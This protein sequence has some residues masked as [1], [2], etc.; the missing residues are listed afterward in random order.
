[1]RNV[2]EIMRLRFG[3]GRSQDA[4]AVACR[5]GKTTVHDCLKR[6]EKAGISWPLPDELDDLALEARL[7]PRLAVRVST[8]PTPDWSFVHA[9]LRRP[10]VT[11]QLL[12]QEYIERDPGGLSYSRYCEL[13]SDWL[14]AS[15]ISMRQIHRAGEKLFIDFAGTTVPVYDPSTGARR[16]AQI[17]VA[18][19][20]ASNYTYAEAVWSQDLPTW[21]GCHVRA[22]NFFECVPHIGVPDNLKAGVDKACRY[23]PDINETYAEL[24]RH[25]SFAVIPTRARAPKD[26]A[27]VEAGVLLVTRWI[28]AALR[29][30][31]FFSL[32]ELNEAIADLLERLNAKPFQKMPG[33]RRS[34]FLSLDKPN[35]Q[36]LPATPYVYADVVKAKVNIDYHAAIFDHFYSAPYQL[37]GERVTARVTSTT[38]EILHNNRRVCTHRR[39]YEAWKHTTLPEHLPKAHRAHAEWT[40]SRIIDWAAKTGEST[41]KLV[42]EIIKSRAHP[43]Q[44][45][46]AALGVI[47]LTDRYGKERVEAACRRA[48]AFQAYRYRYVKSILERGLDRQVNTGQTSPIAAPIN[49]ANIRGSDYYRDFMGGQSADERDAHQAENAEAAG[50]GESLRRD[51]DHGGNGQPDEGRD[52]RDAR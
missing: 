44:G 36:P 15:R 40:P 7:Y 41:A 22:F 50:D 21:V 30:R 45:Y 47:R 4:I 2:R 52:R 5:I 25:Y 18:T 10:G 38:V 16:D 3:L 17:F 6:A 9:E 46:R 28:I 43:E 12:W 1:M 24:A 26:K 13:Y 37:R 27:K 35:A 20:G 11:R 32:D 42:E 8:A 51:A 19:W 48:V 33:S 49:H 14:G 31:R 34:V 23:D 29:H 39:S